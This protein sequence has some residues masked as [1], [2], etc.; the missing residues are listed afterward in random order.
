MLLNELRVLFFRR[1]LL[2]ESYIHKIITC[3]ELS[4]FS[5]QF[6]NYLKWYSSPLMIDSKIT[7]FYLHVWLCLN[8]HSSNIELWRSNF[9]F[10]FRRQSINI[11]PPLNP[12]S[13]ELLQIILLLYCLRLFSYLSEN[14]FWLQL[15][16]SLD[17]LMSRLLWIAFTLI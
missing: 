4:H 9:Y 17:T 3:W 15:K 14:L 16:P 8:W 6:S 12:F 13:L 7:L 1:V 5:S 11:L 10:C 2:S